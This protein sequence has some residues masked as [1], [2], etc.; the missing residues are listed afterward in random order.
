MIDVRTKFVSVLVFTVNPDD[1]AGFAREATLA[2]Q[3]RAPLFHGFVEG[4]VMA[5]E[6]GTQMLIVSQWQS[7][8]DWSAAQWDEELGRTL[9]DLVVGASSFD[10][11]SY[12]PLTV[13][14]A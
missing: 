13:V 8:G 9:S 7:R 3:R 6:D 2:V 10:I 14:R 12:E 1:L 5:N 11:H 4:I